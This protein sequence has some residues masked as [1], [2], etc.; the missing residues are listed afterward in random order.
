MSCEKGGFITQRHN[1]LGYIVAK[2][3]T[4]VCKN[5]EVETVL[6]KL[7]GERFDNT[8]VKREDQARLHISANGYWIKGRKTSISR[9]YTETT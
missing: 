5:V 6:T 4:E 9:F 3:L 7:S 1:E 8:N 2:L